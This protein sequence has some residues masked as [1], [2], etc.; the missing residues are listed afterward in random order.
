MT[1]ELVKAR[2][3]STDAYDLGIL[4]FIEHVQSGSQSAAQDSWIL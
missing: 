3:V 2:A 4:I 1:S